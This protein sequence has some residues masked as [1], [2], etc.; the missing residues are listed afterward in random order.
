MIGFI[1]GMCG[2]GKGLAVIPHPGSL[3]GQ[4]GRTRVPGGV[5]RARL[6]T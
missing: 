3:G 4:I 6:V 5:G 1:I 2:S